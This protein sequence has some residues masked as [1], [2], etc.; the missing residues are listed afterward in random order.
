MLLLDKFHFSP[1]ASGLTLAWVKFLSL[2]Q[3]TSHIDICIP[4]VWCYRISDT[5][6]HLKEKTL[7]S[8]S[9][10]LIKKFSSKRNCQ[11]NS[12]VK[13]LWNRIWSLRPVSGSECSAACLLPACCSG[14]PLGPHL[15]SQ[16]SERGTSTGQEVRG[17]AGQFL[18]IAAGGARGPLALVL[19]GGQ[20]PAVCLLRRLMCVC[21]ARLLLTC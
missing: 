5:I 12:N 11:E 19:D 16:C 9:N 14:S 21:P 3:H 10:S 17:V 1:G 18:Q 8:Q 15:I 20:R 2:T 4:S 7:K 13:T 6:T